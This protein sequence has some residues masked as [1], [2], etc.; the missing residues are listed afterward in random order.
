[1]P[2][3]DIESIDFE[4]NQDAITCFTPI[5]T[6]PEMCFMVAEIAVKKDANY[7]TGTDRTEG[8]IWWDR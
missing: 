4:V 7:G 3:R 8:R 5:I 1:M 2:A 6:Y